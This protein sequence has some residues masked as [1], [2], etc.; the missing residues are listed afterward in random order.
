M[1][2]IR[3]VSFP[4]LLSAIP[5]VFAIVLLVAIFA[6][7]EINRAYTGAHTEDIRDMNYTCE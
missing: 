6:T 1:Q 4:L 3:K 7:V 2:Y 5:I